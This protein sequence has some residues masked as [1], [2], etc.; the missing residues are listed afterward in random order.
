[1]ARLDHQ[2]GW[3]M[4]RIAVVS[5][6]VLSLML[7]AGP[8]A[9]APRTYVSHNCTGVKIRPAS[10][11]FACADGGFFMTE[12][13]WS[14]WHRWRATGH[15]LFH[16]NDCDPSCAGGTFHTAR[17]RIV[18]FHRMFCS[19]IDTYVFGRVRIRFHGTLLGREIVR[20]RLFCPL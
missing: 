3:F 8:A 13:D 1:M 6:A 15:G 10:I 16:Q 12:G 9:A 18:L 20:D 19:G 5:L 14:T 4:K 17:G 11:M 2:E 7:A